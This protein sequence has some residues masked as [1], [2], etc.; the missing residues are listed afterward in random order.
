MATT[1]ATNASIGLGLSIVGAVCGTALSTLVTESGP[2][3]LVAL[4]L[5]AAIPPFIS[6]VGRWRPVRA[7]LGLLITVVA[8]LVTYSGAAGVTVATG[9]KIVPVL[10]IRTKIV[11]TGST[12]PPSTT[13]TRKNDRKLEATPAR[14]TCRPVCDSKVSIKSTGEAP[15]HVDTVEL[16]GPAKAKFTHTGECVGKTLEPGDGCTVD[17]KFKP[18]GATGAQTAQLVVKHD[19]NDEAMVV[20]LSGERPPSPALDLAVPARGLRCVLQPG[21]AA[22]GQDALEVFFHVALTGATPEQLPGLVPVKVSSV[23][24]AMVTLN[25]AVSPDSAGSTVAALPLSAFDYGR[26]HT[27]TITIDPDHKIAERSESNNA[28]KFRVTLPAKSTS[29]QTVPLHC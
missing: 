1:E 10:Q 18:G 7:T 12:T 5:G 16:D 23:P 28:L 4:C 24:G 11:G 9:E 2:G 21:G 22:D 13:P 3:R 27:V 20:E 17:V 26:A 29:R 15:V 25:T 8:A 14:L 19:L 6:T